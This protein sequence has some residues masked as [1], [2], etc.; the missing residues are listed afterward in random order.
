[1][2]HAESMHMLAVSASVS[3]PL[4]RSICSVERRD[5]PA[6][7]WQPL[8]ALH[9]LCDLHAHVLHLRDAFTRLVRSCAIR[10]N[11]GGRRGLQLCG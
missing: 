4:C 5:L 3:F 2:R 11:F 10:E 8:I 7:S 1:M 9:V 6:C